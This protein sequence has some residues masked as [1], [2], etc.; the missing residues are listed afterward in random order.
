MLG[1]IGAEPARGFLELSF[2]A[3]P[4]LSACLIPR[5][6][7]VNEALEEVPFLCW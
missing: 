4:V 7:D 3:D 1:R 6:G 2:A 5:H